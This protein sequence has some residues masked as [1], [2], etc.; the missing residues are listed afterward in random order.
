MQ[1]QLRVIVCRN[2]GQGSERQGVGA[3]MPRGGLKSR[4]KKEKGGG[5]A[6]RG[7]R[8]EY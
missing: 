5:N 7:D 2:A 8:E 6:E 4:K 1:A 3:C